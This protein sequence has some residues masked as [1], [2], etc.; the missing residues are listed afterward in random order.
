MAIKKT[1]AKKAAVKKFEVTMT[2]VE[3][4]ATIQ[5]VNIKAKE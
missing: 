5:Q 4:P 3:V 2:V 1:A